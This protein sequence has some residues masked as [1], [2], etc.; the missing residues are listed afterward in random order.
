MVYRNPNNNAATAN[1]IIDSISL[2][3]HLFS[4]FITNSV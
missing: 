1:A 3:F 4:Q 2:E